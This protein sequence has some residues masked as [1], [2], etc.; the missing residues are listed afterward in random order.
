MEIELIH[1]IGMHEEIM[2][3][4]CETC[5]YI[6]AA[7]NDL[8]IHRSKE[9]GGIMKFICETCGYISAAKNDLRIHMN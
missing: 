7:N 3:F 5:E 9:H 6:S 4:I 2:K 1:N 8:R